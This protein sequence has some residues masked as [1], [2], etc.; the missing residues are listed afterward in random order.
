M[1][2]ATLLATTS[3]ASDVNSGVYDL[4]DLKLGAIQVNFSGADVV[5]T[6]K[7]QAS[8]DNTVWMDVEGSTQSVSASTPHIWD[9]TETGVRYLRVNWDYTSGTG[10]ITITIFIKES[11]V[12][13]Y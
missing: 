8:L 6:L 9:I 12:R 7:L 11:V 13:P 3:A 5:G 2:S 1:L 10:N 4:V